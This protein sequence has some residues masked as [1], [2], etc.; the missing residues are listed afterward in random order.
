MKKPQQFFGL[1]GIK[2]PWKTQTVVILIHSFGYA[3][4]T[5]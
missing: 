4:E 2:G 1:C 5:M 3:V